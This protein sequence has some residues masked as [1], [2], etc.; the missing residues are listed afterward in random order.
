MKFKHQF[1]WLPPCAEKALTFECTAASA[2]LNPLAVD[3]RHHQ[4]RPAFH[5]DGRPHLGLLLQR[6]LLLLE[7][8]TPV[9]AG[10]ANGATTTA[11]ALCLRISV[12]ILCSASMT[13]LS[14][15][16]H[17]VLGGV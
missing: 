4:I 17:E 10:D 15:G 5:T 2:Y 3:Q 12:V 9:I 7:C 1:E 8:A 16:G 13:H 11:S 14:L 6:F